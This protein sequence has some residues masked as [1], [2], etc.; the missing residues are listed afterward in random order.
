MS[1]Y[2]DFDPPSIYS[3]VI[4]TARKSYLCDECHG[5]IPIGEKYE[6][7]FLVQEG[8]ALTCF[9]CSRCNEIVR[10][11]RQHVPCFCHVH[12]NMIDDAIECAKE[13]SHEAP[14][15]LFGI[16]RRVILARRHKAMQKIA[17]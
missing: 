14:G 15:L 17:A 9:T 11:M 1:C 3:A 16:Y 12:G 7:V 8:D 4:H 5:V 13:Y 10:F 6:R 2:C